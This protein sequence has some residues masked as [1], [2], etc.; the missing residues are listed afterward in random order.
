MGV[1]QNQNGAQGE[2][3]Q[4]QT[5]GFFTILLFIYADDVV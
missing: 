5:I 1:K 3:M 4:K 2:H